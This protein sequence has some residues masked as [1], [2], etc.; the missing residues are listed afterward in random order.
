MTLRQVPEEAFAKFLAAFPERDGGHD[1]DAA[2][3]ALRAAL[4]RAPADVLIAGA[5]SYR[6]VTEG[7]PRRYVMS[8]RR[9][10][11][12]GRW[13]DVQAPKSIAPALIWIASGSPEWR[14]W[15][16]H[17]GKAPPLDRRGGWR[18]PTR[19]PPAMVAAGD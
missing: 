12:E 13:R 6:A 10:L 2:L 18:F 15:T 5:L 16:A 19:F 14:A 8:P 3:I 17:R 11:S 7:R 9:W 4:A 1:R